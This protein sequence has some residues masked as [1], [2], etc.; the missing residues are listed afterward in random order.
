MT[1]RERLIKLLDERI[2]IQECS[3]SPDKPLTTDKLADYLL[4][5]GVIVPPCKVGTWCAQ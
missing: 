2:A 3:F 5:H 1:E 4:V